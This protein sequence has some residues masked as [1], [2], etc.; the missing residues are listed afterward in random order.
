MFP[1]CNIV[2]QQLLTEPKENRFLIWATFQALISEDAERLL[3]R[4][5]KTTKYV[6]FLFEPETIA[7]SECMQCQL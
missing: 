1:S 2:L 6:C 4:A 7:L 5:L 3:P